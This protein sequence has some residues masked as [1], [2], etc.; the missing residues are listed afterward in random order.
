MTH[1]PAVETMTAEVRVITIGAQR[2]TLSMYKQLDWHRF[3]AVTLFG[4]VRAYLPRR[5]EFGDRLPPA[6][7]ELIGRDA[8]GNLVRSH[9]G[10]ASYPPRSYMPPREAPQAE[11]DAAVL[12]W[13][14]LMAELRRLPLIVL[15]R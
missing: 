8:A 12:R 13:E 4:R 6:D 15:G 1:T 14:T 11:R 10:V 2:L 9:V 5:D 3:D 7:L